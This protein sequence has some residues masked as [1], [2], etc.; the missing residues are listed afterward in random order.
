[1]EIPEQIDYLESET[2]SYDSEDDPAFDILEESRSK[3]S[4]L[5]IK[6]KTESRFRIRLT[7]IE[8]YRFSTV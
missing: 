4:K 7:L 6:G 5:S 2:D 1:M 3:L 8:H